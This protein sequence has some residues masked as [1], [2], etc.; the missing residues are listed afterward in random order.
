[1][2]AQ[3]DQ[4]LAGS[5]AFNKKT[6]KKMLIDAESNSF[7]CLFLFFFILSRAGLG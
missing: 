5:I 4:S 6:K 7:Y 3:H 1:M 2:N